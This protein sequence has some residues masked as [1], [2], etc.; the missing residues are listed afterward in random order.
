M[1]N[2]SIVFI[3]K[4]N[5]DYGLIER[6]NQVGESIKELLDKCDLNDLYDSFKDC[7]EWKGTTNEQEIINP[8]ENVVVIEYLNECYK[9][10]KIMTKKMVYIIAKLMSVKASVKEICETPSFRYQAKYFTSL[11]YVDAFRFAWRIVRYC[12]TLNERGNKIKKLRSEIVSLQNRINN[13]LKQI[14]D[15]TTC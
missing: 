13:K 15:L 9:R 1:A 2:K 6:A 4:E 5:Y 8:F 12:N 14:E 7:S 11:L 10:N 3:K